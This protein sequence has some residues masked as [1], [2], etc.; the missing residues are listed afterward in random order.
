MTSWGTILAQVLASACPTP[1]SFLAPSPR[2]AKATCSASSPSFQP[3]HSPSLGWCRSGW[4]PMPCL[5]WTDKLAPFRQGWCVP[6]DG[7]GIPRCSCFVLALIHRMRTVVVTVIQSS[8]SRGRTS[9]LPWCIC[10]AG[11]LSR[12]S[13]NGSCTA[14]PQPSFSCSWRPIRRASTAQTFF[15]AGRQTGVGIWVVRLLDRGQNNCENLDFVMVGPCSGLPLCHA[16][17]LHS[18]SPPSWPC[19]ARHGAHLNSLTSRTWPNMPRSVGSVLEA[20][21]TGAVVGHERLARGHLVRHALVGRR[22]S[23]GVPGP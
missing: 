13:S 22:A 11:C 15:Q 10:R 17:P 16:T 14:M 7:R 6:V 19:R 8:G 1:C 12:R 3:W 18:S 9:H 20:I 21:G 2:R 5:C 23:R 4:G